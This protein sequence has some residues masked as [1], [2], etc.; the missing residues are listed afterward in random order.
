MH[1]DD[2]RGTKGYLAFRLEE[3][4]QAAGAPPLDVVARNAR[5]APSASKLTGKKISAWKTGTNVPHA[6]AELESVIRYL[7]N[8]ARPITIQGVTLGLYDEKQ[9]VKWWRE[10]RRSSVRPSID[11]PLPPLGQLIDADLDPFDLEVHH[12]IFDQDDASASTLPSYIKRD[13]DIRLRQIVDQTKTNNSIAV[14]VGGSS[15]GKTRMCWEVVQD[16]EGWRLWHPLN[17]GRPEALLDALDRRQILPRT[18]LWLNEMHYY[19]NTPT[20]DMGERIAAGLRE[21]LK[22][23]WNAPILVLGTV[24]SEYWDILTRW[25]AP[26]QRDEHA[27]ARE[28]LNG[29]EIAIPDSFDEAILFELSSAVKTDRRIVKALSRPDRRITQ[30]LAG[31]F[32]LLSR[33]NVAPPPA[34]AL[35]DAAIDAQRFSSSELLPQSLLKNASPGYM[36]DYVWNGLRDDWF[37]TAMEYARRPCLGVSGPLARIRPRS[38]PP[39][40]EGVYQLAD[41]LEEYGRQS[42]SYVMPPE[43]FWRAIAADTNSSAGL[44]D[45]AYEVN[46]RGRFKL[47]A[48]VYLM[49]AELGEID[50]FLFLADYRRLVG[51]FRNAEIVYRAAARKGSSLAYVNLAEM[52]EE[53]GDRETARQIIEEFFHDQTVDSEHRSYA[54][55]CLIR[56]YG[57]AGEN[58]NIKAKLK[59]AAVGGD[60][61]A[62]IELEYLEGVRYDDLDESEIV[63]ELKKHVEALRKGHASLEAAK[64]ELIEASLADETSFESVGRLLREDAIEE[65]RKGGS[66]SALVMLGRFLGAHGHVEA[67]KPILLKA[68]NILDEATYYEGK[69]PALIE[70]VKILRLSGDDAAADRAWKYGLEPDGSVATPWDILDLAPSQLITSENA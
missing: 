27:Q 32:E 63:S 41:F 68:I 43:S 33:Y 3:L 54:W 17:P 34:R 40:G 36:S 67:A 7:I 37:E 42:R 2:L 8:R 15:T 44:I 13:E 30:Y 48:W 55:K 20:S 6:F 58:Q 51:D 59:L 22:T 69:I 60:T 64:N 23:N 62:M 65:E 28:L 35:I 12:A 50:G 66:S 52:Y 57:E 29:R 16:L 46:Y 24:R 19:L 10:A 53:H 9:W 47:A 25:P 70:F 31:A 11:D 5:G 1:G 38:G 14:L 45:L 21:M 56:I 49:A 39:S 4:W 61:D 18:V 26:F